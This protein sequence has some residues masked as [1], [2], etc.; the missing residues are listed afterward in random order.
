MPCAN[1]CPIVPNRIQDFRPGQGR[2]V[3]LDGNSR[4]DDGPPN[5]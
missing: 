3:G 5:S 2:D 4:A 1:V